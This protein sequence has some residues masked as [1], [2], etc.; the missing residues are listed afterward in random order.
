MPFCVRQ[1]SYPNCAKFF[2]KEEP[3]FTLPHAFAFVAERHLKQSMLQTD[4][5]NPT[6]CCL[7]EQ[8]VAIEELE[9][10]HSLK[11]A[12]GKTTVVKLR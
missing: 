6:Y 5:A 1:P 10:A 11:D 12:Q 2:I 8:V 4:G 9:A 3:E 7:F